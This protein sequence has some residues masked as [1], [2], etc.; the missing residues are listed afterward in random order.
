MAQW[1]TI[2]RRVLG[3]QALERA[4]QLAGTTW[5][6]RFLPLLGDPA[7]EALDLGCGLGADM[8]RLEELG[9]A[10]SGLDASPIAVKHVRERWSLPAAIGDLTQPLPFDDERFRL[11]LSRCVVHLL[12]PASARQLFQEIRRVLEPGGRLLFI[13]N[14]EKH[15]QQG[16]Q[17]DYRDAREVEPNYWELSAVG[18]SY[19]FYTPERAQELLGR[20][21]EIE[22]LEEGEFWQWEIEK[23]VVSGLA[24]RVG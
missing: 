14:S 12:P 24:R 23:V 13:V 5:L 9:Y 22:H 7:G 4:E 18:R 1:D 21:W 19:L 17:Y 10:P 11:V 6:D 3:Q 2:Y 15:R 16:L 8:L 20:G